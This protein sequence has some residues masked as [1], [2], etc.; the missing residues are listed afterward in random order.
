MIFL[1]LITQKLATLATR[2]ELKAER[3]TIAKLEAFDS[4]YFH[5]KT[6]FSDDDLWNM[7]VYQPI[8]NKLELKNKK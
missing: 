5:G 8:F 4:S 3:D 6:F 7:F 1:I 2:A